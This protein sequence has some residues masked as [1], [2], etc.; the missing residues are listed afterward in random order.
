MKRVSVDKMSKKA[1]KAYYAKNRG[2]TIPTAKV[3]K[4]SYDYKRRKEELKYHF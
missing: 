3:G 2:N 1:K 4:G